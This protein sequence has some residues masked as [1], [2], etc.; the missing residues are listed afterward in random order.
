METAKTISSIANPFEQSGFLGKDQG[1]YHRQG[2]R[3]QRL[4]VGKL[5]ELQE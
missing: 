3:S 4:D 1:K 5:S 2:C